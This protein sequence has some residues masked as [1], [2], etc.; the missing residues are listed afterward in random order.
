MSKN[1]IVQLFPL[2]GDAG[3][4]L[5]GEE[6]DRPVVYTDDQPRDVL[7]NTLKVLHDANNPPVVFRRAGQ[8]VGLTF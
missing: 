7:Q 3:A 4:L 1:N 8:L 2:R 5:S 6:C